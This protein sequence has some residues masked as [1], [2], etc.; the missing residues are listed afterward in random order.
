[1]VD[2]PPSFL[3]NVILELADDPQTTTYSISGLERLATPRAEA[4]LA[5]LSAAGN[6]EYIR[7]MGIT[8]LGGLGDPAYCSLMLDI[9]QESREYSRF[10]A[11]RAAGYLCGERAMPLLTSQLANADYSSRFEAACA[12]GNTHSR[13]AVPLLIPLLL[14]ADPNLRRAARDAL[15]TLTHRRSRSDEGQSQTAHRNWS[16]W[17]A[18]NGATATIYSI[19]DCK[20]PEPL[21]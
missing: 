4:K 11:L 8:A 9:A 18:S 10:I 5:E 3:E 17:W 14:D 19:D 16:N 2:N 20:Q 1:V 21:Q 15:A 12:L 6:P 13:E 7:Q